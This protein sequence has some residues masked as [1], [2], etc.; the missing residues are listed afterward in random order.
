MKN[1]IVQKFVEAEITWESTTINNPLT[2]D[3]S[4]LKIFTTYR[5]MK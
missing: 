5:L 4:N 2:I 1:E 3:E